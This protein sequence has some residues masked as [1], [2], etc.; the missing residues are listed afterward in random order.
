[1]QASM[2]YFKVY[3]S[4]PR[5]REELMTQEEKKIDYR[6]EI[7]EKGRGIKIQSLS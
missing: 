7:F 1:M 5:E 6:W 4:N 3:R 2:V